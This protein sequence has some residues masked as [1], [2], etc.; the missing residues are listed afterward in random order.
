M[1]TRDSDHSH[2][3]S[4]GHDSSNTIEGFGSVSFQTKEPF[5][6]R[7]FQ[8]FLDNQLSKNVFRAKGILWFVE[9]ERKHIFHLAGKR[10]SIDD[11]DWGNNKCN[12]IVLIGKNLNHEEIQKQ[13]G[14]CITP[15]N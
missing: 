10:F 4:H 6:L 13:L 14:S 1:C 9:S 12:K 5:S 11:E 8:Y 3:H 2:D 7:K 15:F